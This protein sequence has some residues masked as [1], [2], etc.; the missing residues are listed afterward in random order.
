[1]LSGLPPPRGADFS[2]SHGWPAWLILAIPVLFAAGI[3]VRL[4]VIP[5][6]GLEGDI[7]QFVLWVHGIAVGGW[8]HAYDQDL[9]FPAVMA[10]IWG[11][12]AAAEPA[13]R[14]VTTAADPAIRAIM[15]LPASL[16]DLGIAAAVVW[17]FR[18][19]PRLAVLAAAAILLWPATWYVSAWWGQYESIYVLPAVLALLA[20]RAERPGLTAAL[21]AVSLMTKPQA[22]PFLVP[23]AAWFL[24]TQGLR[25]TLRGLVIGAVVVVLLW[26][27]FIAANGPLNYLHNLGTYQNTIF[28]VL[29]LRA[30][31]PWWLVQELGAGGD[32]VADGTA[33]LGP[34]TFR[35]L[36]FLFAGLLALVVFVAVFRRPT[37][38][39]LAL[40]L[41]AVSLAAFVALTT[42]HERY[43]YPTLV[44][45]LLGIGRPA[46]AV[47]WVVFAVTFALNLVVAIPPEGW[48]IPAARLLGIVGA[49]VMTLVFVVLLRQATAGEERPLRVRL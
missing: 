3:A 25:G 28:G 12:L 42:M 16:A 38:D 1:V 15:K 46:V 41:A 4:W 23:F 48:V 21:L 34:L 10:W 26:L 27:P 7:D 39:Q 37:A 49:V 33:I 5:A 6:R 11:L 14:T 22:L 45:L 32:F 2:E 29:S 24:A 17:W 19:R 18:D 30:W 20:A 36:G 31:N 47:T 35:T 8:T 13:F 9:S 40:G 44:F 43:A